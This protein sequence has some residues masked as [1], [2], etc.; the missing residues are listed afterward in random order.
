MKT[1]IILC[2]MLS[3]IF[4]LPA[5]SHQ[6]LT[7]TVISHSWTKNSFPKAW[8]T[9]KF[10]T[11]ICDQHTLI[12]NNITNIEQLSFGIERYTVVELAPKLLQVSWKESPDTTNYGIIWTLDFNQMNINGVLINIDQNINY[13]VSGKFSQQ[14]SLTGDAYLKSC[15]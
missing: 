1:T 14:N 8:P 5:F 4:C 12:W 10:T 9:P 11:F 13:V 7:G 6:L 2:T 3:N 15:A